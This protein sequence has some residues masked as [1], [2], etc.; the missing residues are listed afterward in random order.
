METLLN[1]SNFANRILPVVT[2][3]SGYVVTNLPGRPP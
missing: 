1:E 3:H 2:F